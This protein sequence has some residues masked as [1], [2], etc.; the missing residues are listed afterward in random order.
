M[1]VEC[2]VSVS[3]KLYVPTVYVATAGL[4]RVRKEG[5]KVRNLQKVMCFIASKGNSKS[6]P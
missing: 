3:H 5:G 2:I 1:V 4:P 6:A